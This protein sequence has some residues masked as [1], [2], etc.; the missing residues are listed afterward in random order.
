MKNPRIY[1]D[2]VFREF[3]YLDRTSM[4]IISEF[5]NIPVQWGVYHRFNRLPMWNWK[6]LLWKTT[7]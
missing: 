5:Y 1:I 2:T 6:T 3:G 4:G 7:Q